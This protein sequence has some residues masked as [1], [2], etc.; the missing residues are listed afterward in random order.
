MVTAKE[1]N[2]KNKQKLLFQL[3]T[4]IP[5]HENITGLEDIANLPVIDNSDQIRQYIHRA[6]IILLNDSSTKVH[7][8]FGIYRK[9]L[10]KHPLILTITNISYKPDDRGVPTI[11]GYAFV[12]IESIKKY[13]FLKSIRKL[14]MQAYYIGLL[15]NSE[16]DN[17]EFSELED[18]D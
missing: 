11:E 16:E 1:T 3:K 14:R 7:Y 8:V 10:D 5:N 6:E 9:S 15:E 18:I 13:I 2:Y 12:P 17:L 4:Q